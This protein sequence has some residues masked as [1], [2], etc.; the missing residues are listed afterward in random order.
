MREENYAILVTIKVGNR[1]VAR[2]VRCKVFLPLKYNEELLLNLHLTEKQCEKLERIF[3]FSVYGKNYPKWAPF[4]IIA[5]TVYRIKAE[6]QPWYHRNNEYVLIVKPKNLIHKIPLTW[7]KDKREINFLLTPNSLL[8]S[9]RIGKKV[10]AAT[11][12][13]IAR[14]ISLTFENHDKRY[15]ND[16]E[17]YV[18]FSELVA[19]CKLSSKLNQDADSILNNYIEDVLLLASL[20]DRNRCSCVG[21]SFFNRN[22]I[23]N[24][25]RG[26]IS[27]PNIEKQKF[28]ELIDI[29]DIEEYL[30]TTYRNF[31]NINFKDNVRRAI[32]LTLPKRET[33][34]SE[35]L[36]L[37][38]GLETLVLGF[39]RVQN[40]EF[41]FSN[42]D[43]WM[44]FNSDFREW[45][46]EVSILK[47]DNNKRSLIYMNAFALHR[48][49]L[50]VA[51][52]EMCRYYSIDL[53]DLW[54]VNK[55]VNKEW[56][57]TD[58]RNNLV[59]GEPFEQ[60]RVF[61]LWTARENL[62]WTVER[63]I[64]SV[65]GWE[66]SRSKVSPCNLSSMTAYRTWEK[67]RTIISR[68]RN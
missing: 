34:E 35:F 67:D 4:E 57:L 30:Q 60:P 64:L 58:I 46:K 56:S 29:A 20:A 66:T 28:N 65:L 40:R 52:D 45:V 24:F 15:K 31:Q 55:R 8:N 1:I 49:P 10:I 43:E 38:T 14:G 23:T 3:E 18:E 19:V 12:L 37:F 25:Y 32:M 47:D 50:S 22:V 68:P 2:N 27:I 7:S 36:S 17:E 59:H 54:S 51:F 21:W 44:Q 9:Q 62:R 26:D 42:S 5:Q 39:R 63:L 6:E 33:V 11:K 41:V 13:K 16:Q 53:T 61:S 48:I